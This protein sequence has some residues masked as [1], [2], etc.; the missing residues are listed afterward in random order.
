MSIN[1][2]F[3]N[4]TL[5]CTSATVATFFS[6]INSFI[7]SIFYFSIFYLTSYHV[8]LVLV[9][10]VLLRQKYGILYL[11][12]FCSLNLFSLRRYLKTHCFQSA[13]PSAH[14]QRVVNL[15]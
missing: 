13:Y 8:P 9:L 5:F 1:I 3:H 4:K 12:T 14:T 10:F 6:D 15:F 2:N 7:F 11:L